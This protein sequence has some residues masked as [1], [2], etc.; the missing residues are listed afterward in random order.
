MIIQQLTHS[1]FFPVIKRFC[2]P[3][4]AKVID[5]DATGTEVGVEIF[6]NPVV[7]GNVVLTVFS[8]HGKS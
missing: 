1:L 3:P 8:D 4:D 6:S 5:K 2:L 7:H